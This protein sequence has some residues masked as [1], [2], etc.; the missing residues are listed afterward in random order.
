M[1]NISTVL[2]ELELSNDTITTNILKDPKFLS[3]VR[4]LAIPSS[5]YTVDSCFTIS[6]PKNSN[7]K[8]ITL[9]YLLEVNV[10]FHYPD[11]FINAWQDE[12]NV[13]TTSSKTVV[14]RGLNQVEWHSLNVNMILEKY[15]GI[16][17]PNKISYDDCALYIDYNHGAK[18]E[19]YIRP[20]TNGSSLFGKLPMDYNI[21]RNLYDT[22]SYAD[23][24]CS[25]PVDFTRL[26]LL[27]AAMRE[28]INIPI[29]RDLKYHDFDAIYTEKPDFM[30]KKTKPRSI[31]NIPRFSKVIKVSFEINNSMNN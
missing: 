16:G 29:K 13:F 24:Y 10:Y 18:V 27:G 1:K 30:N 4:V 19:D 15:Y 23:K 28:K 14:K 26:H 3:S 20:L 21:M 5:N 17:K 12:K 11:H 7:L 9:S 25:H 22:L 6:L 8:R 31:I 2:D